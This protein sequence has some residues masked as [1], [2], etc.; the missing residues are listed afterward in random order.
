MAFL[1]YVGVIQN[2]FTD[3]ATN[4]LPSYFHLKKNV[5]D[6]V[7]YRGNILKADHIY[8]KLPLIE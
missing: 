8:F 3:G 2:S 7:I 1:S 5:K 4:L 6:V